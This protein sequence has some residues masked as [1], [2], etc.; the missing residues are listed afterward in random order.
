ME[1]SPWS[2]HDVFGAGD[3]DAGATGLAPDA[4]VDRSR[5]TV[6]V[7]A[8][9][10]LAP[11]DPQLTVEEMQFFYARMRMGWVARAGRQPYQHADPVPFGVGREQLAFDPGRDL[12]PFRLGPLPRRWRHRLFPGLL[13]N[14][15]RKT[16]LQRRR[17]WA[18]RRTDRLPGGCSPTRAGNPGT[19]RYGLRPRQP[20]SPA[21]P[22]EHE[23]TPVPPFRNGSGRGARFSYPQY[24]KRE[25][26]D[27]SP[28]WRKERPAPE[29]RGISRVRKFLPGVTV[30]AD[31]G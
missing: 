15:K 12:F 23:R 5:R 11:V 27:W 18:R 14:A 30:H 16:P 31:D 24:V 28:K 25:L 7:V 19:R 22:A 2:A 13:G 10:E 8:R 6:V 26:L 21:G 9:D 20:R 17:R 1:C 29:G 4:L 3:E